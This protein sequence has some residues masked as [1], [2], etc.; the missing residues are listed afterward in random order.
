MIQR[1]QFA[2]TSRNN[3][4][5]IARV[6]KRNLMTHI[7]QLF[8]PSPPKKTE[9]RYQANPYNEEGTFPLQC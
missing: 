5:M 4:L 8:F 9:F 1:V 7:E 6:K 3:Q 2:I